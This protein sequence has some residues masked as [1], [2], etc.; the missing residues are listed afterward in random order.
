MKPWIWLALGSA[1]FAGLVGVVGKRGLDVVDPTL[2][3]AI[4]ATIMAAA[5][6][7]V[8]AALGK[9]GGIATVPR[10]ALGWIALSGACGAAS[11]LC[12]FWALRY[13]PAGPVAALDRLS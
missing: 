10:S 2:G 9:A 5:L 11:W 3:T 12:Y 6:A 8:T 7:L 13:G 1:L 4:R